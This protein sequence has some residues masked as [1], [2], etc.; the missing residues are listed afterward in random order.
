VLGYGL[1]QKNHL[2]VREFADGPALA[3][4]QAESEGRSRGGMEAAKRH[5]QRDRD[6]RKAFAARLNPNQSQAAWSKANA[7]A[8]DTWPGE[9][10]LRRILSE[11]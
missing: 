4:D 6:I 1:A 8:K 9:H 2:L 5:R 10:G 3:R 11:R 7:N